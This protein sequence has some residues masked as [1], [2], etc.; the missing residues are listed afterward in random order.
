QYD[1]EVF[2]GE[3]IEALMER[4]K[5]V[6]VGMTAHPGRRVS[7]LDLLSKTACL[8]GWGRKAVSARPDTGVVPASEVGEADGPY[9]PP[10]TLVEQIL[11]SIYAE[12]LGV[13]RVDVEESFFDAGGDSIS[14]MRAIAAINGALDVELTMLALFDAP[15]VRSLAQ[16]LANAPVQ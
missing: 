16:Q 8:D 2:D 3:T 1:T 15:S 11:A 14:A 12:V 13:D 7:S 5:K 10:A 9:R 6:L 4:F